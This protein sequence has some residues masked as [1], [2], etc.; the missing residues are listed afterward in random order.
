MAHDID[1]RKLLVLSGPALEAEGVLSSLSAHFKPEFVEDLDQALEAMRTED[2]HAVLAET[3]DF[4]P[5]E[6]GIVSQQAAVVLDTV[7]DGVCVVGP[8]GQLVWA[9]RRLR[10]FPAAVLESLSKLCVK[11]YE[12]LD[13]GGASEARPGRRFTLMPED[14]A[15]Y[16]V[17]CSPI[18]DRQ[19][20]LRQ[21]AAVVVNTTEHRRQQIRLNAI[22]Q[23]G[24][25]LVCLDDDSLSRRDAVARL[26]IL[27]ERIIQ[28]SK[29]VLAF[30]NFAVLLLDERSNRLEGIIY[31]GMAAEATD[32][33]ASTE[34]SGICGYVAATGRSYI[35]S[36]V[37]QDHRYIRGM[38]GA[39]SSLTVPLRLHNKVIGVI[40]VES[41]RPRAYAEEDR[42]FAEIFANY[43]AL[44]LHILNLLVFEGHSA[45]TQ[46]SGSISAELGGPL[47]DII[48]AAG[49]LLEDYI[50]HDDIR[51]RLGS[52]ID[53]AGEA[54]GCVHQLTQAGQTGVVSSST[55]SEK[56][57][58]LAGKR[59]LVA[60]DEELIRRTIH[61]VLICQGCEVEV[62]CDGA[63]AC[64][65]LAGGRYDLVLSDIKM[66]RA[67]GYEVFAAAKSA[68]RETAVILMTAFGYD[69]AHSIVRARKED[70]AAVLLKPF[71]VKQLLD[72]CRTALAK[73]NGD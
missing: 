44:A 73:A 62:A 50:G 27:Q 42:Q 1:V 29:D 28:Y 70:L 15:Y 38:D 71:K 46:V 8:N 6:R 21:I 53:L 45:R 33:F 13:A 58:L 2:F 14:G 54:R 24:R 67:N 9:N 48:T 57:P 63:E 5:L 69:P 32:L 19:G 47:N 26:Q 56:D 59:I 4:L 68:R 39:L 30:Q 37:R 23:A 49:E 16:E 51:K 18:R 36:D 34:G 55:P 11:A 17:I 43:V 12:D 60:E 20:L 65:M 25:E 31:E 41:D 64:E 22:D 72:E 40:N 3:G 61:D 52:I 35:C 10:Q 7:G 66:P